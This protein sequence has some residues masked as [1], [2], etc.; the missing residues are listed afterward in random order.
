MSYALRPSDRRSRR[1][2]VL[3]VVVA[4]SGCAAGLRPAKL[5]DAQ[6]LSALP[7]DDEERFEDAPVV[8]LRRH[9]RFSIHTPRGEPIYTDIQRHVV[10]RVRSQE[11]IDD[12]SSLTISADRDSKFLHF[13]ARTIS[14]SGVITPVDPGHVFD[15]SAS[16]GENQ[17]SFRK[18]QF[19]RVEVGSLLEYTYT[20]RMQG[21]RN[22]MESGVGASSYPVVDYALEIIAARDVIYEARLHN[23]A[24]SFQQDKVGSASRLRLNLRDI[25]AHES[26]DFSPHWSWRSPWWEFRIKHFAFR[27]NTYKV[28]HS[29][30][31]TFRHFA[32]RIY[33]RD[34]DYFDGFDLKLDGTCGEEI[35]CTLQSALR[36]LR[37][38]AEIGR[39]TSHYWDI[40]PAKSVLAAGK[41]NNM[42]KTMLLFGLLDDAGLDARFAV[43]ARRFTREVHKRA[44]SNQVMNHA[45]L[46]LPPQEG[47][48]EGLWIDPSCEWCAAGELPAWSRGVEA[49]VI[50][51]E[52]SAFQHKEGR[53][54][55]RVA[56]GRPAAA[57]RQRY[58]YDATVRDNGD[59]SV[60]LTI[61]DYG[62]H[63]FRR[64]RST[65]ADDRQEQLRRAERR[66]K[67]ALAT[68]R[69]EDFEPPSCD[70]AAG[71]CVHRYR[72]LLPAFATRD[73]QALLLPLDIFQHAYDGR[74]VKNKRE[75][76][77]VADEDDEVVSELRVHLPA[78][79][80]LKRL[81]EAAPKTSALGSVS[82]ASRR[83]RDGAWLQR[84]VRMFAGAYKKE[85]Y[86]E[87]RAPLTAHRR[88]RTK[89]LTLSPAPVEP[90][91]P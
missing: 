1:G 71:R 49:L 23:V 8:A 45:L 44:P 65:R 12:W 5:L 75:H 73:G 36:V 70:R 86:D 41:A 42:E 39:F 40:R 54:E 29:W 43:L 57:T 11:G 27:Y 26:S 68:A 18:F 48:A 33:T 21:Y 20:R 62:A 47:L 38:R 17:A 66:A 69:L 80:R 56:S 9:E 16:F 6:E 61:E 46:Y 15:D 2:A 67:E 32:E 3:L 19:P 34:D 10:L 59:V 64:R 82:F 89:V 77:I 60:Q 14:P 72:Y 79:L 76:D 30:R 13:E 90:A 22:V 7:S 25:P 83:E 58:R 81:P 85:R 91:H 24:G 74:L 84:T 50:G 87:L 35:D 63:A 52:E 4:L 28:T 78:S 55:W 51:Y 37:E 31:D 88:Y 53:A